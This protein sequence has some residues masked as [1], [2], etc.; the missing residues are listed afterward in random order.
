MGAGRPLML[1]QQLLVQLVVFL[2]LGFWI[3]CYTASPLCRVK[4][5]P[6]TCKQGYFVH[7]DCVLAHHQRLPKCPKLCLRARQQLS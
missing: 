1:N 7:Y 5:R 3:L 4:A 2:N 6:V